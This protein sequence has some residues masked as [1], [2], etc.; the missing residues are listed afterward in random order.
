MPKASLRG[1]RGKTEIAFLI[2]G[3]DLYVNQT[4]GRGVGVY[5]RIIS[6]DWHLWL[7]FI[8]ENGNH[9]DFLHRF[10]FISENGNHE[11]F[12]SNLHHSCKIWYDFG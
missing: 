8:I 2:P 9:E 4:V 5:I 7:L 11:D 10:L 1:D 3:A 6:R 12:L